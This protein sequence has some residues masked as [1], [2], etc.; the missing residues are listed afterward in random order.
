M[1]VI[2]DRFEN[3]M[4]VLELTDGRKALCEKSL[5]PEKIK[6]GDVLDVIINIDDT[7]TKRRKKEAQDIQDRLRKNLNDY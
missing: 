3:N 4:V 2:I 5:L 1:K 7:E 6:E